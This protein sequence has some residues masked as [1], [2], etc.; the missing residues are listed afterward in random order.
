M[1]V[2]EQ[3]SLVKGIA[4]E[5][6]TEEELRALFEQDAH[7]IAYDGF[8]PSGLAHLPV[9][10]YRPLLLRQLLKAGVRFKILLAD[11][12]A[13][14]NE[15]M[16]G[17]MESVRLVG[18]YFVEVWKASGL[19]IGTGPGKLQPVSHYD[20]ML[21]NREYWF[22]VLQVARNHSELRTKRALTIAGRKEEEIKQMAQMFYPSMQAADI[23]Q[24]A[25]NPEKEPI[26]AQLGM[27]QRKANM[28]ARD[29]AERIGFKKPVAVHHR[30]LLGLDGIQSASSSD[31]GKKGHEGKHESDLEIEFKMSKSRPRSSI[32]I[33]DSQKDISE[34]IS[35]AY[36]PQKVVE[37]NPVLEYAREIVFRANPSKGFTIERPKKFGGEL[38]FETYFQL[39][40]AF[41]KGELHPM[42]LK[43]GVAAELDGLIA[44]LRAHFEK[45][46]AKELYEKVRKLQVTR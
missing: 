1:D 28:L 33:H 17:D 15:K 41:S 7:P 26:I 43:N 45:G 23:F 18:D 42:D 20:E 5:I 34:K 8:E 31:E 24:L 13:W 35:K 38:H 30:M 2:E 3:V 4:Q 36:C 6:V 27:D 29:T 16:A 46:R 40:A 19:P 10:V 9:G 37:G 11:S 25:D 44:P 39:E 22:R 32:F 14:I 12:Y 21:G